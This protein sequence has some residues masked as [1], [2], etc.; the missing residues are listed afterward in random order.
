MK[1]I[2]LT[3]AGDFAGE[4]VATDTVGG[5]PSAGSPLPAASALTAILC[6]TKVSSVEKENH[7]K[8]SDRMENK[9]NEIKYNGLTAGG[10]AGASADGDSDAGLDQA[11]GFVV[12]RRGY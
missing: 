1:K 7:G 6:F 3:P 8:I 5:G 12:D 2:A 4:V 10:F 9:I 11:Q